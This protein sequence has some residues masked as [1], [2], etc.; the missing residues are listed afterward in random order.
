MGGSFELNRV[1]INES[2]FRKQKNTKKVCT[3]MLS[4]IRALNRLMEIVF[5]HHFPVN[6]TKLSKSSEMGAGIFEIIW[7]FP[8]NFV[9]LF[10]D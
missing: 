7:K 1:T 8:N 2:K 10:Q 9:Y 4:V 3:H 5:V 6:F